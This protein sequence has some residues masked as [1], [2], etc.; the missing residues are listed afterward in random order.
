M[1][2]CE[3]VRIDG[4]RIRQDFQ[5]NVATELRVVG[6]IDLAHAA[7]ADLV[8]DRVWPERLADHR[9]VLGFAV[10]N[11]GEGITAVVIQWPGVGSQKPSAPRQW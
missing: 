11:I 5:R 4:E 8:Q 10:M 2:A 1:K 6:A 7:F 9:R 3:P